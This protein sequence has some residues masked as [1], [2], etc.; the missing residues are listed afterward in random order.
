MQEAKLCPSTKCSNDALLLG[1]V[2]SDKTI[3]L[4]DTPLRINDAFVEKANKVGEL[5]KRFRFVNKC[6]KKG[7]KQWTG[8]SC[9]II[10][11]LSLANPLI[12]FSNEKLPEC[13]I[14]SNCRWYNQEGAKA[15]KICLHVITQ[16]QDSL[17]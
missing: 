14:R 7:C 4:L 12:K 2:Q 17:D 13:S 5:E 6:V 10:N 16:S 9:G 11:E 8:K 15:C 3:T 1:I